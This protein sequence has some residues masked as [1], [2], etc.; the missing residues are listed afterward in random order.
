MLRAGH[1]FSS[2]LCSTLAAQLSTLPAVIA[3]YG[4]LPLLATLGNLAVVPLIL[5]GMYVAVAALLLSLLWMPLGLAAAAVGDFVLLCS[6]QLTRLC[7]ALPAQR[8]GACRPF[9]SG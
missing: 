6:T 2:L 4:E 5:L 7:A 1:Y 9:P 3:Y 8:L